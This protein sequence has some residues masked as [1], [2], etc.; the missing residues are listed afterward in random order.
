MPIQIF[1]VIGRVRPINGARTLD[2]RL[3]RERG[4]LT[5]GNEACQA[6]DHV[7]WRDTLAP[8]YQR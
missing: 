1:C 6:A 3:R 5:A 2:Q 8:V 7:H 4:V